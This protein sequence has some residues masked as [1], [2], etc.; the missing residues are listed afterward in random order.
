MGN[1]KF[2]KKIW[3]IRNLKKKVGTNNL[4]KKLTNFF[5]YFFGKQNADGIY[6]G[7]FAVDIAYA[8]G[9]RPYAHEAIRRRPPLEQAMP[10]ANWP[11]PTAKGRRHSRPFL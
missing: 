4:K 6:A 1:L 10:T 7:D 9:K 11:V 8:D 2:E 3:K 5:L